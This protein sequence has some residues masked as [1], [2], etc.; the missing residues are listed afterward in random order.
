MAGFQA[1]PRRA[2]IVHGEA[3]ATQALRK[4]IQGQLGWQTDI[5]RYR[6]T[7]AL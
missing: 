2:F 5:P 1:A 3:Q 6:E 4:R 7:V